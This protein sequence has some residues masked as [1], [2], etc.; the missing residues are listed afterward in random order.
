MPQK[1][2][3][4]KSIN[5]IN[6]AKL[7]VLKGF[8]MGFKVLIVIAAYNEERAISD[9]IAALK[10]EGYKGNEIIVVDD[11]S[12]DNTAEKAKRSGAT[13]L[14]HA[15]NRGQGAALRTG[16]D[17]AIMNHAD[18]IVHFDADG[19]HNP[20]EIKDVILPII[21]KEADVVLG[22]RFL[23]RAPNIPQAYGLQTLTTDSGH[24]Q[25]LLQRR[26]R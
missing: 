13:V 9:V 14:K 24:S 7:G 5:Y 23:G 3:K 20:K 22:S 12:K 18:I 1:L 17:Y 11:G 4:T 19:Q 8:I 10:K 16:M 15:I 25:D 2:L 21:K 6:I 26:L